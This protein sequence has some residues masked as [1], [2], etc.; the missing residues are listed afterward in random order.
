M[1]KTLLLF[2][3]IVAVLILIIEFSEKQATIENEVLYTATT[4][5][6]AMLDAGL[7]LT[8]IGAAIFGAKKVHDNKKL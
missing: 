5:Q 7:L 1:K 4:S 6:N 3:L 8:L 2:A